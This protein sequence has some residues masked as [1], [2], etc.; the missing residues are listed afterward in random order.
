MPTRISVKGIPRETPST[1]F[2]VLALAE[3]AST[4]GD[5]QRESRDPCGP[6]HPGGQAS[7]LRE[8]H[9]PDTWR[10]CLAH[11]SAV[12]GP[13]SSSSRA[14]AACVASTEPDQMDQVD[15]RHNP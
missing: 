14:P 4:E 2:L 3:L 13:D 15:R 8:P 12:L 7:E 5:R 9:V 10:D 6:E 11:T 1:R